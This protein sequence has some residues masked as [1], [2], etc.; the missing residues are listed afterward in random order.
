[1]NHKKKPFKQLVAEKK[2]P[3]TFTKQITSVKLEDGVNKALNLSSMQPTPDQLEKINKFTRTPKTTEE[4]VVL[5]TLACNDMIDRD[6]EK[7]STESIKGFLTMPEPFSPIGKSFLVGHDHSSLPIGRIFDAEAEEIDGINFLKLYSYIPNIDANKSYI[8]NVDAGVYWAVSVGVT[9]GK[10]TCKIGE[11]HEWSWN[12]WFCS[13]GHEKGLYYDPKSEEKD[14]LGYPVAVDAS[15]GELCYRELSDPQDF[16]ELSQVYLGAQYFA[17]LTSKKPF[18]GIKKSALFQPKV[19]I[20]G[21]TEKEAE[22]LPVPENNVLKEVADK[23]DI[24]YTKE[25]NASWIDTE[26]LK[27]VYTEEDNSVKCL[28]KDEMTS[29]P[30]ITA[31]EIKAEK[32]TEAPIVVKDNFMNEEELK[33]A[34][35]VGVEESL[36]E[37]AKKAD[38]PALFLFSK[39]KEIAT[40]LKETKEELSKIK[41]KVALAENYVKSVKS[42]AIAWYVKNHQVD[43]QKAVDV[44]LFQKILDTCGDDIELIKELSKEQEESAKAKF[45]ANI[46]Q[47]SAHSDPHEREEIREINPDRAEKLKKFHG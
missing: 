16:Y 1:M 34:K 9:L 11:D 36:I 42:D 6:I 21:L 10:A 7:F 44:T 32:V 35:E 14:S 45:P 19:P 15:K 47:S 26:N 24:A 38:K 37:E 17:E 3:A 8:E 27:W 4:V 41:P 40:S 46:R 23:Y 28:G 25:G 43:N 20:I 29:V 39:I 13:E 33:A 2:I 31:D 30:V 18:E 22:E 5:P 12:P